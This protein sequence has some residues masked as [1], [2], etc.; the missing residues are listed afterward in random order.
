MAKVFA[1]Y[2]P[3]FHRIEQNN[4]WWGKGFTEWTNV[5]KARPVF[6][7]HSQPDIPGDLGFY[8]LTNPSTFSEQAEL[9]KKFDVDGFIF[10]NYWFSGSKILNKPIEIFMNENLDFPF[11]ICWANENWTKNW[12]GGNRE[13]LIEQNYEEGFERDYLQANMPIFEH[14]D[15]IR[16][17]NKPILMIYRPELFPQPRKSISN[18]RNAAMDLNLGPLHI[19]AVSSFETYDPRPIGAD[20]VVEFPPFGTHAK[21]AVKRPKKTLQGFKGHFYDYGL[22]ALQSANQ[23]EKPFKRYRSVMAGWDNTPRRQW[24]ST[25]FMNSNPEVF[26]LWLASQI[27]AANA[28]YKSEGNPVFVNAWNEWAEGAHLEPSRNEGSAYLEAVLRAKD[29]ATVKTRVDILRELE[30]L[31]TSKYR[32]AKTTYR[33]SVSVKMTASRFF[34]EINLH[35]FVRLFIILRGNRPIAELMFA[36]RR[37]YVNIKSTRNNWKPISYVSE[38]TDTIQ[39]RENFLALTAHIF[40]DDYVPKVIETVRNNR[41][42][43]KVFITTTSKEIQKD[44]REGLEALN[45]DHEVRLTENRG[46]NF[47]PLL[48]EF[49]HD[50]LGFE[51]FIHLHS[52]KSK[53]SRRALAT[54][55]SDRFWQQL[56][57]DESLLTRTLGI[58]ESNRHIGVSYPLVTDIIDPINFSMLSNS[59]FADEI[60]AK[61]AMTFEGDRFAYPAGGMFLARTEALRPLLE[62]KWTS[63]DFPPEQGQMDGTMQHA[64]ERLSGLVPTLRGFGHLIYASHENSF[65]LD[66]SFVE[67]QILSR[68]NASRE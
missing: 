3:Q 28:E 22:V 5:A 52:K 62:L 37:A 8:D 4:E 48:T 59:K 30:Q 18:F 61:I 39:P 64:I 7:G 51:Y 38:V 26:S 65:T 53:H 63:E 45:V 1:F 21:A 46:R 11:A 24:D 15:Y 47:G 41:L 60:L 14:R 36:T 32:P 16:F 50:L 44:L 6:P 9:A 27:A 29:I 33:D 2:L 66:E 10:Y 25:I 57:I 55:W 13:V 49:S 35:N 34:R 56:G 17:E 31:I 20:A 12:D 68:K 58:L 23:P 42:I 67:D 19:I 40:Y 43:N 54:D